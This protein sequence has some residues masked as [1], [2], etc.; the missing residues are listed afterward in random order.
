MVLEPF[1]A[2]V[3]QV[4]IARSTLLGLELVELAFAEAPPARA[5]RPAH[6]IH[7]VEHAGELVHGQCLGAF[8]L[9]LRVTTVEVWNNEIGPAA[10]INKVAAYPFDIGPRRPLD[11]RIDRG[12][13]LADHRR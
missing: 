1:F 10:V 6:Q 12:A 2:N 9:V 7:V 13:D 3:A 8:V 4:G 11:S 5:M